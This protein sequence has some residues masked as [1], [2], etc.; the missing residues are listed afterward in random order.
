VVSRYRNQAQADTIIAA[1]TAT[2]DHH[3]VM[4]ALQAAGVPAGAAL[5]MPELHTD[6]HVRAR[7]A[8]RGVHHPEQGR[9][10]HTRTAFRLARFPAAG[11]RLPAPRFG[12]DNDAVLLD[13]L[14]RDLSE[15]AAMR[16]AGVVADRP[17]AIGKA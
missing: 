1:W 3:A 4:R 11:P 14:G 5:S 15:Y 13:L 17:R 7:G 6:P 2:R 9:I 16:A 12:Q 8:L 10:P